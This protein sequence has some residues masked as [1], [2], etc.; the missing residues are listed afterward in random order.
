MTA[1]RLLQK[2]KKTE[3]RKIGKKPVVVLP[4][5]VWRE[6]E[7]YLED[8]EIS[9]SRHLAAKIKKAR[10]QK[11]LYSALEVKKLPALGNRKDIYR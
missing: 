2:I 11:K 5:S 10:S 7:D 1:Q 6:I 3:I 8:L 9:Q 4:L